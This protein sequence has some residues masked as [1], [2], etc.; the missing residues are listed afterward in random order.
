MAF[1]KFR[2]PGRKGQDDTKAGAQAPRVRRGAAQAESA[3]A[4]RR[5]ARHRLIGASVLVVLGVVGFPMLFDTQPRP[6]PVDIPISIPDRNKAPALVLPGAGGTAGAA[7]APAAPAAAG[8]APTQ[9]ASSAA[10]KGAQGLDEGEEVVESKP[11]P[12]AASR[13]EHKPEAKP[14]PK[15]EPKPQPKPAVA[16]AP[17]STAKASD[18]ARALA[19]LEGRA[20]PA[21]AATAAPAAGAAAADSATRFVVQVGAFGELEK[22]QEVRAKLERNGLKTY[23][24]SIDTKDGKR[25]RVRVGPFPQRSEADQAASRIRG[26]DLPASVL[27]L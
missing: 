10:A 18:A 9:V 27:T 21:A 26:L 7:G 19:L 4:L 20:A 15:P 24:Q 14:E 16:P 8:P 23:V 12:D 11:V 22:A 2:W 17:A 3:E 5:R 13:P 25:H 6:V 1:F